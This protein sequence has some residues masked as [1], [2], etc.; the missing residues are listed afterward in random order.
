MRSPL[1]HSRWVR[2]P[3]PAR[4]LVRGALL[5]LPVASIVALAACSDSAAPT[6]TEPAS[7]SANRSEGRGSFQRYV[8]LGTGFSMG[9]RSDGLS[10][11]SQ[12]DSWPAQLARLAHREMSQPYLAEPGCRPLLVA[13]LASG[14]RDGPV[15]EPCALA[16]GVSLPSQNLSI[17][18]ATASGALLATTE[19]AVPLD[20]GYG[21][22]SLLRFV[23]PPGLTQVGAMQMLEPKIV[24]VEYGS[25]EIMRGFRQPGPTFSFTDWAQSYD[26]V[27]D[28]VQNQTDNVVLALPP[29]GLPPAYAPAAANFVIANASAL[30]SQFNVTVP[31]SCIE[32]L[33]SRY[34]HLEGIR[35]L[36]VSGLAAKAKGLGPVALDCSFPM[37]LNEFTVSIDAWDALYS[38]ALGMREH[39]RQ[40]AAL[41]GFA[42]FDLGVIYT[43]IPGPLTAVSL[44]TSAEPFGPYVSLDGIYPSAAGNRRLADAAAIALNERYGIG[45]P[46]TP[47]VLTQR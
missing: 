40:Q 20:M 45:I 2:A 12:Y 11:E 29:L 36:A 6:I 4:T 33:G 21:F 25:S 42:V 38:R 24:S 1:Y 9:R 15:G 43:S 18:G 23:L 47:P 28:A 16:P 44:M 27:L 30:L 32:L 5:A 34:L 10:A 17:F 7:A 46:V 14:A 13:P 26:A 35:S 19:N 37:F 8:A 3:G 22:S 31:Q 39:I 41:R